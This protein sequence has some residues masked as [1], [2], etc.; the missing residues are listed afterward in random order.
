MQIMEAIVFAHNEVRTITIH[1]HGRKLVAVLLNLQIHQAF[2]LETNQE[3]DNDFGTPL[4]H[5][6][7]FARKHLDNLDALIQQYTKESFNAVAMQGWIKDSMKE[8]V[9]AKIETGFSKTKI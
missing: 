9:I 6:R 1:A 3:V 7:A 4:T 2:V 8:P 5:Q